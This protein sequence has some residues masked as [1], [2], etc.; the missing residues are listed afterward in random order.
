MRLTLRNLLAYMDDLLDPESARIIGQKTGESEFASGL[1][2]RIRDVTRRAKLGAPPVTDHKAALDPNTVAEYLDNTLPSDGVAD[3]EKACLEKSHES[4]VEL[5]EVAACHQ[6]LTLVLGE[7]A[8]VRPDSRARMYHLPEAAASHTYVESEES[9]DGQESPRIDTRPSLPNE[10]RPSAIPEYLL[11]ARRRRRRLYWIVA[12]AVVLCMGVYLGATGRLTGLFGPGEESS[13]SSDQLAMN[14]PPQPESLNGPGNLPDTG[15]PVSDA[16]AASSGPESPILPADSAS[17]PS[18]IAPTANVAVEPSDSAV[19]IPDAVPVLPPGPESIVP[20]APVPGPSPTMNE[21]SDTS[22]P[23]T[24]MESPMVPPGPTPDPGQVAAM[25]VPAGLPDDR[26][27]IVAEPMVPEVADLGREIGQLFTPEKM[28]LVADQAGGT[29]YR[30]ANSRPLR[31]GQRVVSLPTSRPVILVD[32][33]LQVEMV[34]GGELRLLPT[35]EN[36]PVNL[37]I[38]CG[39]MLLAPNDEAG[40]VTVSLR[41]GGLVG[42]LLLAD[43]T[44]LVA[45]EVGRAA[46]PIEDPLT[47][48]AQVT[49]RIWHGLGRF[50]W[51][52]AGEVEVSIESPMTLDLMAGSEPVPEEAPEWVRTDLTSKLDD[53]AGRILNRAFVDFKKSA[54]QVLHENVSHRRREVRRLVWRSLSWIEDFDPIVKVLDK[55]ELYAEW[56]EVV[57]LLCDSVRR[58][59]RTAEAVRKSMSVEYQNRGDELYELLWKYDAKELPSEA[60]T[61]LVQYLEDESLPCR[62]LAFRNLNRLTGLFY[63]YRPEESNLKRQASFRRWSDWADRLGGTEAAKPTGPAKPTGAVPVDSMKPAQPTGP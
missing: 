18:A 10:R 35:P 57:D 20:V 62:V 13:A 61:K 28:A 7:P 33:R 50:S 55:A 36:G 60:A 9:D 45:I 52:A 21:P 14:V 27:P 43:S 6:I 48:P 44:T 34:D 8:E 11:E 32:G 19:T 42:E 37:E 31:T 54:D 40:S 12:S 41:V 59:P 47:K 51:K 3:F 58:N 29:F 24:P 5:A 17:T 25:T 22:L 1:L 38:D 2:H 23:A 4:D 53:G 39:R 49:A 63:Y 56:P 46:G 26:D 15:I 16:S 30:I